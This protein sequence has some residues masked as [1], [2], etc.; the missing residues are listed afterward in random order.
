MLS[1]RARLGLGSW[2]FLGSQQALLELKELQKRKEQEIALRQAEVFGLNHKFAINAP[3]CDIA[4][5]KPSDIF[6]IPSKD[7]RSNPSN[8]QRSK[9]RP[10]DRKSQLPETE[11]LTKEELPTFSDVPSPPRVP[12]QPNFNMVMSDETRFN[13]LSGPSVPVSG[14]DGSHFEH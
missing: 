3:Q 2:T 7:K 4:N 11:Q 10:T 14:Q 1:R 12:G 8:K 6:P 13:E 5:P 9:S